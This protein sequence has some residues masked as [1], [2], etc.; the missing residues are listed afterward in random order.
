MPDSASGADA[1]DGFFFAALRRLRLSRNAADNRASRSF[2]SPLA[3]R[4][5][6]EEFCEEGLEF[7]DMLGQ[8]M[9]FPLFINARIGYATASLKIQPR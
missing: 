2:G 9:T 6:A 1:A 4:P 8:I 5:F 3:F 7:F